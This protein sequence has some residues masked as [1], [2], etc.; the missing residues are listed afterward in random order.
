M[1]R[2]TL[3]DGWS[4]LRET[5]CTPLAARARAARLGQ[6]VV[7][8][9]YTLVAVAGA[10][11]SMIAQTGAV[12]CVTR[13][14]ADSARD[15]S[16]DSG[17]AAGVS[18]LWQNAERMR[19][20][21]DD[22]HFRY[23]RER[24]VL[25]RIVAADGKSVATTKW[26]D[27][28]TAESRDRPRYAAWNVASAHERATAQQEPILY[29]PVLA[30]IA[31]SA[32][33]SGHCFSFGGL[34]Q[35]GDIREIRIDFRPKGIQAPDV[36]GSVY[37]DASRHVVRKTVFR[38]THPR[39]AV[40]P[41][42]R[43]EVVTTFH[44]LTPLVPVFD[45]LHAEQILASGRGLVTEADRFADFRFDSAAPAGGA[46][47]GGE[48][49]APPVARGDAII[50]G[51]VLD[52][53][54]GGAL[55]GA[56]IVPDGAPGISAVTDSEGRFRLDGL[57]RGQYRLAVYHPLLDSLGLALATPPVT[58]DR[59]ATPLVLATPS[60]QTLV[61][62]ACPE[63]SSPSPPAASR[64]HQVPEGL[65]LVVGRVLDP[66]THQPVSGAT[67][68]ASWVEIQVGTSVG[69]HRRR[70]T[71]DTL[72]SSTG[73]FRFCGVPAS[74]ALTVQTS[75]SP[76]RNGLVV[77]QKLNMGGR[78]AVPVE[79]HLP[80]DTVTTTANR[81]AREPDSQRGS[82]RLSPGVP[83]LPTISVTTTRIEAG[84]ERVG[85]ARRRR[86]RG[87]FLDDTAIAGRHAVNFH[88]LLVGAPGVSV[89]TDPDGRTYLVSSRPSEGGAD[90]PASPAPSTT[91]EDGV[92]IER[93]PTIAAAA[94]ARTRAFVG[95]KCG[96][97]CVLYVVDGSVY[98]EGTPGDID[99]YV[100]P[101]E[102]AAIEKYD[103]GEV[104]SDLRQDPTRCVTIVIWTKQYLTG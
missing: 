28:V 54:R 49:S 24:H 40:P 64:P 20:L 34:H 84:Y 52:S 4:A 77:S 82:F 79:L 55:T 46:E 53:L 99:Q 6:W 97:A 14:V 41:V 73:D 96:Q 69:F 26:T 3:A 32:F 43:L 88:D 58:A 80:T 27:T 38:L 19:F 92:G 29:L 7:R 104:P 47:S 63:L 87:Y 21:M 61:R 70:V 23:V 31:D 83:V 76:A 72:T 50:A 100:K 85:F 86:G 102:I 98:G 93:L 25:Q 74:G 44:E 35:A 22:R 67:V 60:P 15:A 65:A 5:A 16:N 71:R 8:L 9:A 103:S 66:D 101:N 75:S 12:A 89:T 42:L 91:V 33:Q 78:L 68:E 90:C 37:L 57:P 2:H 30:D 10:N 48:I 94:R 17:F 39:D 81:A 95:S 36:E 1:T 56:Q 51:T 11:R 59:D 18:A 13:D 45:S 62:A